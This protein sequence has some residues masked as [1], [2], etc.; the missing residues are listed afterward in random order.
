MQAAPELGSTGHTS[1]G[2]DWIWHC[3]AESSHEHDS[4]HGPLP[5]PQP[6]T[7]PSAAQTVAGSGGLYGHPASFT[8]CGGCASV[9]PLLLPEED[10]PLLAVPPLLLPLPPPLLLRLVP[11]L[12][13]PEPPAPSVPASP[14]LPTLLAA[15]PPQPAARA[16]RPAMERRALRMR[17]AL[18]EARAGLPRRSF[19][20]PRLRDVSHRG[21]GRRQL[22]STGLEYRT[23]A[24]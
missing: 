6:Q 17:D 19:P 18:I 24:A 4:P 14:G 5:F 2:H 16:T 11:P 1:G 22:G 10:P 13:L 20:P 3:Q 7:T 8:P 9:A 15:L 12:P 21:Q 23:P